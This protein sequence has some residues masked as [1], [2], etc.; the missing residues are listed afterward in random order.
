[1]EEDI[2]GGV[3]HGGDQGN[4]VGGRSRARGTAK[5]AKAA[6]STDLADVRAWA[7]KNGWPNIS[8]RGRVSAEV[9]EAYEAAN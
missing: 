2:L 9:M 4:E 3:D 1:M 8:D 6:K 7:R 5:A